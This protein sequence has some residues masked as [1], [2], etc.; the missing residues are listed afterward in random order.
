MNFR[1]LFRPKSIAVIGVS[2]KNERHPANV[3]FN[4]TLLRSPVEVFPVNPKG[5]FLQGEKIYR[6]VSEITEKIELAVIATRAEYVPE[7]LI[8]CIESGVSGA[9]LI[10]GGFAE[11]GRKDLQD[12]IIRIARQSNFPFIG[13]NCLG[14]YSPG[15]MD[16]FFIPTERMIR[17]W[18]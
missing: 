14:I 4:K 6:K 2:Q 10:S 17:Q 15:H 18:E 5:G 3:I 12:K 7:I 16:T 8:E 1:P 13:P 11:V 9:V